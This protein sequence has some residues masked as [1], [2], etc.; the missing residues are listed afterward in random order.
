MLE[1]ALPEAATIDPNMRNPRIPRLRLNRISVSLG[2][3]WPLCLITRIFLPL[4]LY[5]S[6]IPVGTVKLHRDKRGLAG[7]SVFL[8]ISIFHYIGLSSSLPNDERRGTRFSYNTVSE[9]CPD[10]NT[11]ERCRLYRCAARG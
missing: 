9:G 3:A 5:A 8:K 1:R 6:I 7:K 11:L 10:A 2:L 4:I